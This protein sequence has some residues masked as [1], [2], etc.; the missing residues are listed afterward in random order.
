MSGIRRVA[1]LG[2]QGVASFADGSIQAA[3][4]ASNA[5]TT[6]KISSEAVTSE[7]LHR[8]AG[9]VMVFASAA[10]RQYLI[11]SPQEGMV[12]YLQDTNDIEIYNGSSWQGL[13]TRNLTSSSSGTYTG[14]GFAEAAAYF[15]GGGDYPVSLALDGA[16]SAD[17]ISR[18]R[19]LNSGTAYWQMN[20]A[21]TTAT[22]YSSPQWTERWKITSDGQVTMPY[23]PYFNGQH[24]G[25]N[26]VFN[27]AYS[28][29]TIHINNGSRFNTGNG[30]FTAGV[31]GAYVLCSFNS[32]I[33]TPQTDSHAYVWFQ[34][35]GVEK[36]ARV[37]TDYNH[38]RSY[39]PLSNTAVVY[40]P[41]ASSYVECQVRCQANGSIYGSPW[42][43]GLTFALLG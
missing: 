2:S 29:G 43:G 36:S 22:L 18:V 10:L 4:I 8:A 11:P 5:V 15:K 28:P 30:R 19:V 24:S 20:W 39:E 31:A 12:T 41:T 25:G 27:G 42:G 34:V 1:D 6:A 9:A 40:L 17:N 3:D 16:G 23:Q 35:D 32:L 26:V 13:E 14:G 33:N 7:K 21:S 37:H 38:S